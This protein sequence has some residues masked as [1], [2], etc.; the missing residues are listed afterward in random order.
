MTTQ[1]RLTDLEKLTNGF[2]KEALG[3]VSASVRT[4]LDK[5]DTEHTEALVEMAL[6]AIKSALATFPKMVQQ[7]VGALFQDRLNKTEEAAY[8]W[9]FKSQIISGL[10]QPEKRWVVSDL[11]GLEDDN[12][13]G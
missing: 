10:S 13:K 3:A 5:K 2:D 9:G 4:L 8:S 12:E 11:L 7:R 1:T 6:A